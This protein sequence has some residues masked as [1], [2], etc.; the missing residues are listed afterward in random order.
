MVPSGY[1]MIPH[2]MRL[3]YLLYKIN[4]LYVK[5][6]PDRAS[7]SFLSTVHYNH[8]YGS[9]KFEKAFQ[10]KKEKHLPP[11]TMGERKMLLSKLLSILYKIRNHP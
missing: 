9:N 5:N 4:P 7:H 2:C 6:N 1:L 11:P 3:N 8:I 10:S